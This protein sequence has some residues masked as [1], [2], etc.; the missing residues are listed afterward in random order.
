MNSANTSADDACDLP[1][2]AA[3]AWAAVYLDVAEK[4]DAEEQADMNVEN[5]T[6]SGDDR[7]RATSQPKPI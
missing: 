5:V 3:D 1:S 6:T 7:C 2:A 4:L